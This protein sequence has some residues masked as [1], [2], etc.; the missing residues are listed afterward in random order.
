LPHPGLG[1]DRV[2]YSGTKEA[3]GTANPIGI[4]SWK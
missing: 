4:Y 2:D 3:S 1:F